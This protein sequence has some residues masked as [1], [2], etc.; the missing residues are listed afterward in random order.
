MDD[1]RV[2]ELA[3]RLAT[4]TTRRGLV[5]A[6]VTAVLLQTGLDDAAGKKKGKKGNKAKNKKKKKKKVPSPC[7]N[8]AQECAEHGDCCG[9]LACDGNDGT[10]CMPTYATCTGDEECCAG[11]SCRS[12]DGSDPV[13]CLPP[14][15]SCVGTRQCCSGNC[16]QNHICGC[17][18]NGTDCE[19]SDECCG[20]SMC[21]GSEGR[22]CAPLGGACSGHADCCSET[23]V[24]QNGACSC[25][26]GFELCNGVCA[27]ECPASITARNPLTCGC[28]RM[29]GF[30]PSA[31]NVPYPCCSGACVPTTGG[32]ICVGSGE[33]DGCSFDAQCDSGDCDN[34]VCEAPVCLENGED[35]EESEECCGALVCHA[36]GAVTPTCCASNDIACSSDD[37]CCVVSGGRLACE[38][39]GGGSPRCCLPQGRS[40]ANDGQCCSINCTNGHCA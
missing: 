7:A 5:G 30:F 14:G 29:N 26:A 4:H 8:L 20:S 24:C 35:C 37:D 27:A 38:P 15:A 36:F 19:N 31:C 1:G 12:I 28:C 11:G 40:C 18:G 9:E 23:H 10:C 22:C 2:D 16:P 13:C 39:D 32:S 21:H 25:Q 17:L 3:R 6:A 33:G 34:G